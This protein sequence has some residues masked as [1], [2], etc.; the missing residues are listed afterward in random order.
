MLV[1]DN[2]SNDILGIS[3]IHGTEIPH[4]YAHVESLL[5][6]NIPERKKLTKALFLQKESPVLKE[7][8]AR[9]EAHDQGM[10][11]FY[12]RNSRV[13]EKYQKGPLRQRTWDL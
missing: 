1:C 2:D 8:E 6:K 4:L 12:K 13:F 10:T 9:V 5:Q 11:D 3:V 7:I